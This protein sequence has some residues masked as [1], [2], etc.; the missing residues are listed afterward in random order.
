MKIFYINYRKS[1]IKP[2]GQL[3][4]KSLF[5]GG[6]RFIYIFFNNAGNFQTPLDR[7]KC[8]F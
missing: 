7:F 6:D 8:D 2:V 3:L 5:L 1:H 4:K